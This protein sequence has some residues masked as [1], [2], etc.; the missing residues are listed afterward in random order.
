MTEGGMTNTPAAWVALTT[1]TT[2]KIQALP[3]NASRPIA[4]QR[5]YAAPTT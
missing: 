3:R 1:S 5:M 4:F 2:Q